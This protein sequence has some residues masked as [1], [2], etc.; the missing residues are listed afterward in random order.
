MRQRAFGNTGIQV[1]EIGLGAWQ[2]A[3]PDWR[4][5]S[6]DDALRVVAASLE[7]GCTFFDTAPGYGGGRSEELLGRALRPVRGDVVI[8]TKFSHHGA[9]GSTDFDAQH[10]RPVLEGSLRRLQTDYVDIL[11]LHNPPAP[12]MNG[13]RHPQIYEE[14]ERLRA[15][16][17]IREYGI[18]L[19]WSAELET[20]ART[21]KGRAA[22]VLFNAFSQDTRAAF[23]EAQA[24]G[25]GLIVK[26]PLDSGWLSGRYRGAH[27]FDDVRARWSPE[28]LARRTALVERL[29]ALVPPGTRLGHAA[30]QYCL[31]RP[32]VATVIPGAKTAEQALDNIAAASGRLPAEVVQAIDALWEQEIRDSPLPW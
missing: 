32:E 14:L 23:P 9:D 17:R 5:H 10:I 6:A 12:L 11:L 8:C 3:N 21:T 19:D 16:G 13:E 29:A 27:R 7:A 18:S 22:E 28:V 2:L 31:A 26:V 15:E 24:R 1:S 20:M 4:L 30:L 25:I